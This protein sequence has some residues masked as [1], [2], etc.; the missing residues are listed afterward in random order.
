MF[1]QIAQRHGHVCAN[2]FF[3]DVHLLS[4]CV[5]RFFLD[6]VL[7][8]NSAA[9]LGHLFGQLK[10]EV[11][12]ALFVKGALRGN[13]NDDADYCPGAFDAFANTTGIA[14]VQ[15][16]KPAAQK[17][18]YNLQGQRVNDAYRGIVIVNGKKVVK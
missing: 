12:Q 13:A 17:Y 14:G 4:Y 10:N 3:R 6:A 15:A 11:A 1:S 16:L 7:I 9:L 2:G 8:E 5:I 18:M